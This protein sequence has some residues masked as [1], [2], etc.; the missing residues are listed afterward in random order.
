[1][2]GPYAREPMARM[3][4]ALRPDVPA[5]IA[6]SSLS[7]A[8]ARAT[9][10][11]A[12]AAENLHLT[13]AFVGDV[14]A[15]RVP[16][17][18]EAGGAI[19]AQFPPF[20][21]VLDRLGEF[22]DGGIAWIGAAEIPPPLAGIAERLAKRLSTEGFRVDRRAYAP[23]LTL[24]RRCRKPVDAHAVRIAWRVDELALV[25]SVLRPGGSSYRDDSRWPLV[26]AAAMD[27]G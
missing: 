18:R 1:M 27:G 4:F 16:A 9:G 3:F 13:L 5:R 21:L 24:A 7:H 6:L 22:R 26:A 14:A 12:P 15:G 20:T 11:R 25:E 10:G 2:A 23:H 17:L 19:A 8:V